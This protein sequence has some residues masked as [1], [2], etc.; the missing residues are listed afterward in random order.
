[1]MA[2][3][4]GTNRRGIAGSPASYIA[5]LAAVTAVLQMIPFSV[6]LGPGVSFPLSLA[7]SGLIGVLL[8]PWAGTLSVLIGSGIGVMIA[9]HTAFMGPLTI[10]VLAAGALAGGLMSHGKKLWVAGYLIAASVIWWVLYLVTAGMP[11]NLVVMLQPWRYLVAAAMLLIPGL[12]EKATTMLRSP[13]KLS[14]AMALGFFIWISSQVDHTLS[15]IIG[16]QLIFQIPEEVWQILIVGVIG[17][18]RGA[19]TLV[20]MVIGTGV[21]TGLRQMGVR[22]PENSVW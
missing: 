7:I 2:A 10:L 20:G 3:T 21:I 22:R 13:N 19:L 15:S 6:V 16:N 14:L 4:T 11:K 17:A 9:P 18:E 8:G 5:L 1:M 12:A